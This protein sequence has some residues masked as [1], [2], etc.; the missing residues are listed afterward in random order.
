MYF[1]IKLKLIL[2]NLKLDS[3]NRFVDLQKFNFQN[4]KPI[5]D[6]SAKADTH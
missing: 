4:G 2:G 1:S 5:V 6:C 3:Q